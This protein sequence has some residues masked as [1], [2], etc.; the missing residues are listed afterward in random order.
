[1]RL[2]V[3]TAA[4]AAAV[5]GVLLLTGCGAQDTTE[6][7]GSASKRAAASDKP[8]TATGT[9]EQLAAKT[10]CEVNVEIDAD[11]LRRGMCT[12]EQGRF[13]LAT[14]ATSKGQQSWL[15]EAKPYGGT[16]LVGKRWVAV[17]E[18]KV[19]GSVR[20]RLGGEVEEGES[21]TGGAGSDGDGGSS[22]GG[23]HQ[24]HGS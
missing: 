3:R 19:L 10:D 23:K 11:E 13:V 24:H 17:G 4:V 7:T 2:P 1:M 8:S 22:G 21:H 12:T 9:L 15:H 6:P 20:G 5:T 16:Y 18:P 14:F